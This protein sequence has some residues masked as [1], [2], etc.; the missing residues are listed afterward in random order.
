MS[1]EIAAIKPSVYIGTGNPTVYTDVSARL[2][3]VE[4]VDSFGIAPSTAMLRYLPANESIPTLQNNLPL[5]ETI[6]LKADQRVII[7]DE[8]AGEIYFHGWIKQRADQGSPAISLWT[9]I[10]DRILL[11]SVPMR[12]CIIRDI[13]GQLRYCA[14]LPTNFNAGG[15]WNCIGFP[16]GEI[17]YPVFTATATIGRAYES[18]DEA[19]PSTLSETEVSPWTPRR[20]LQYLQ[21]VMHYKEILGENAIE[22]MTGL[23][24]NSILKASLELSEFAASTSNMIGLDSDF[25]ATD[26]LDRRLPSLSVQG[27][28]LLGA[29]DKVLKIAGTH[30]LDIA[31][32][33]ASYFGGKSFIRYR[34]IGITAKDTGKQ[35]K[36]QIRGRA[37]ADY[38]DVYDFSLLEDSS[39]TTRSVVCEGEA[40]KLET[41]VSYDPDNPT[42]AT[43]VPAWS[44]AE[45]NGFL[46]CILGS[47]GLVTAGTYAIVPK[48]HG[49]TTSGYD[50]CDGTGSLPLISPCTPEA[51]ALARSHFPTVFRAWKLVA[52]GDLAT[53]LQRPTNANGYIRAARPVLP[54]QLQFYSWLS[55]TLGDERLRANLPIRVLVKFDAARYFEVPRDVAVRVTAE[56]QGD[57]LIWLDGLAESAN[58]TEVCIY[59][60]SLYEDADITSAEVYERAIKINLAMPTDYRTTG[61]VSYD[62]PARDSALNAAFTG[63]GQVKYLDE[64]NSYRHHIQYKS[65]PAASNLYFGGTTGI[66]QV[67][68]S[69]GLSRDV[70]PGSEYMHATYAAQ[71]EMSRRKNPVR[72][73]S[74]MRAGIHSDIVAGD[75]ISN[76]AITS[77]TDEAI[78]PSTYTVESSV[79]KVTFDFLNQ[80]T[81]VGDVFGEV[82]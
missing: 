80:T 21:L 4:V 32:D 62:N 64:P 41:Q 11:D 27:D 28:T 63:V 35:L 6:N 57:N 13:D 16:I 5:T 49:S 14:T 60:G 50:N 81:A 17:V 20:V 8:S 34:S 1:N 53:G 47:A 30:Q 38:G 25:S 43:I 72:K 2:F 22:G 59:N 58:G 7:V 74:W 40:V 42:V 15:R 76:I 3:A 19:F 33:T 69:S 26:P 10:D 56:S 36:M 77:I 75:W 23:V 45:R 9:A 70:P 46:S 37:D 24:E 12:G 55:E 52:Q 71:R 54:E 78:T 48:V 68:G 61:I 66:V 82:M 79:G 51:V 44:V 29:F 18:P 73:S 67:D 65:Y 31:Y 39:E